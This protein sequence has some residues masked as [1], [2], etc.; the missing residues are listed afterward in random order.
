MFG[1]IE[2]EQPIGF[3]ASGSEQ[4]V[5]VCISTNQPLNVNTVIPPI[6][7]H[8]MGY[9]MAFVVNFFVVYHQNVPLMRKQL[10]PTGTTAELKI[11]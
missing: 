3:P 6:R 8:Q 10:R 7:V 1:A 9:K 5:N 4:S 11:S 2:G